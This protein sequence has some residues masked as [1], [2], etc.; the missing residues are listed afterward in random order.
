M[1]DYLKSSAP[2]WKKEHRID[3]GEGGW[4]EIDALISAATAHNFRITRAELD[5]VVATNDK[6]R[7][8]VEGTRIR[9][10]QG[11]SVEVDLGL[12]LTPAMTRGVI[13]PSSATIAGSKIGRALRTQRVAAWEDRPT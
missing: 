6:R 3:G 4:V 10:S 12:P 1:M 11:H 7:F 5:H 13:S 9:A 2:F 8:A